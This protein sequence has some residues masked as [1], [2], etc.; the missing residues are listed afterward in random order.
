M[1]GRSCGRP[2]LPSRSVS[3]VDAVIIVWVVL[4]AVRGRALGAI[5]QVLGLA[6]FVVGIAVGALVAVP[7]GNR[8]HVGT[9]RT[10]VTVCVVLGAALLGGIAGN[11]LG[12][13]ANV[14]LRRLHLG[15]VDAVGGAIVA[16]AG[17][18]LSAWLVAGLF[19]QSSV[20]WLTRP[21]QHSAVLTAVDA[22]MPPVPSVLAHAEALLSTV[23]F[24]QVFVNL[25]QPQTSAVHVPTS[26]AAVAI[27][28]ASTSSVLK[29]LASG[30][31]GVTRE[32][33]SFVVEPG[34]VITDAHVVAGEP[35]LR[36]DT[37][38]GAVRATLAL[39]D[40]ELDVAVLRVPH[41]SLAP[42]ALE[43]ATVHRGTAAAVV[44]YPENGPKTIEPAGV[45]GSFTAEGRDIYGSNLV[46]RAIYAVTASVRPGNSG[47]PLLVGGEAIGMVF[48]RSL[49]QSDTGYA[50]RASGLETDVSRA[51]AAHGTVGA[52][53]CTPG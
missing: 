24:P 8:L 25:I 14:F 47:S 37:P 29:V 40:P 42:I 36:V 18:L 48:S 9:E 44:G 26:G 35:D 45:A 22:V 16:A 12:R 13:W 20:S 43:N 49:S 53:A 19:T 39:F 21:I 6:G 50:L 32:G 34:L 33:T 1:V 3:W 30:G 41:L 38:N 2:R 7:I 11:V 31:C 15:A 52:G 28:G 4:G 51:I 10:V 17:A 27:A 46:E 5:T 23:V